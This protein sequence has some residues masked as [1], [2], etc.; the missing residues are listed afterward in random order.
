MRK[1]LES[2]EDVALHFFSA[3]GAAL[4]AASTVYS[5]TLFDVLRYTHL[6]IIRVEDDNVI[7]MQQRVTEMADEGMAVTNDA[8]LR[9]L[10]VVTADFKGLLQLVNSGVTIDGKLVGSDGLHEESHCLCAHVLPPW[11]V[12]VSVWVNG[13]D[14]NTF[15]SS[16][17][18]L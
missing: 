9:I 2:R 5:S 14:L 13:T 15:S 7:V 8:N 18:S 6:D 3:V 10:N 12:V 4:G 17:T 16:T 1:I 11:G